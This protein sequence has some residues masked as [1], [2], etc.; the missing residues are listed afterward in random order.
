MLVWFSLQLPPKSFTFAHAV[1]RLFA[2]SLSQSNSRWL[3]RPRAL[4]SK[5]LCFRN[6]KCSSHL[7]Y[8]TSEPIWVFRWVLSD[9]FCP[10]LLPSA[11][12]TRCRVGYRARAYC[13]TCCHAKFPRLFE[14]RWLYP[15]QMPA[16]QEESASRLRFHSFAH[17]STKALHPLNYD[18]SQVLGHYS[19]ARADLIPSSFLCHWLELLCLLPWF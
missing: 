7:F 11:G 8:Q 3:D 4:S 16:N 6:L 2:L 14:M 15:E 18:Q 19:A 17:A 5:F 10:L 12:S 9:L 13:Q 1:W